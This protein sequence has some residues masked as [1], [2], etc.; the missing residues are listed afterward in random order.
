MREIALLGAFDRNNYGD[1]LFP[2]IVEKALIKREVSA[3]YQYFGLI[4]ADMNYLGAVNTKSIEEFYKSQIDVAI[5][6]GG[7]VLPAR[8]AGMDLNLL[9]LGIKKRLLTFFYRILLGKKHFVARKKLGGKTFSPWIIT[10]ECNPTTSLIIYNAVGGSKFKGH[11]ENDLKNVFR[12]LND[13]DYISVR[14]RETSDVLKKNLNQ[15]VIISPDSAVCLSKYFPKEKLPNLVSEEA[16]DYYMNNKK[17]C[18]FQIGISY[19]HGNIECIAKQLIEVSNYFKLSLFLLPIGRASGHE[20]QIALEKIK[21]KILK[22][23]KTIKVYLPKENNI[24]DTMFYIANSEIFVGTSLH[25]CITSISYDVPSVGMD[26][27]VN[28]LSAFL[29][30]FSF[31]EQLYGVEYDKIFQSVKNTLLIESEALRQTRM[32]LTELAEKNFDEIAK[33][34]ITFDEK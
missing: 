5:I 31:S 28:K 7:D 16:R 19:V 1:L 34:I 14:D 9:D 20:D 3:H 18:V 33:K 29:K 21:N 27:R 13:A 30:E 2:I 8:W 6:S 10:K 22:L 23:D 26:S 24:Y 4:E 17:Y 32:Q 25:G 12:D 15:E 11:T